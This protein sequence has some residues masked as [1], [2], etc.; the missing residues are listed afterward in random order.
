MLFPRRARSLPGKAAEALGDYQ[1]G[2]FSPNLDTWNNGER[3]FTC[4]VLRA[5][6]GKLT[7]SLKAAAS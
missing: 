1:L 3:T 2:L 4:Y 7:Q 5:D 6:E